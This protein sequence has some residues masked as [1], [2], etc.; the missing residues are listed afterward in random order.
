MFSLEHRNPCNVV[1]DF[2]FKEYFKI[3]FIMM[4]MIFKTSQISQKN[5]F[6]VGYKKKVF[7]SLIFSNSIFPPFF[8]SM[9]WMNGHDKKKHTHTQ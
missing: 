9:E 1:F 4:H 8:P 6:I 3:Y 7:F 2:K 5:I